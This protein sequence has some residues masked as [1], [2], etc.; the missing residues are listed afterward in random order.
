MQDAVTHDQPNA[1][2]T[3]LLTQLVNSV[4]DLFRKETQLFRVE[5]SEAG[6]QIGRAIGMV[7]A[8]VVFALTA[9]NVL[10]AALVAALTEAGIA[11]GWAALI[12]GGV[13]AI[14]AF[15]LVSK[16][17]NDLKASSLAPNKSMRSV[18]KDAA[19]VKEATR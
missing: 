5:L 14:I 7:V 2:T 8:G 17:G 9:L 10:S 11:G 12:V 18:Q 4:S 1:S 19:M 15:A 6:A 3:G 13:I 16:G